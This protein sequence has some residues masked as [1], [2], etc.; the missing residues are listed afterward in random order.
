MCG[1]PKQLAH[2]GDAEVNK[3]NE[4]ARAHFPFPN[5]LRL[6]GIIHVI[7]YYHPLSQLVETIRSKAT[8][9]R[10][11]VQDTGAVWY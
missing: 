11:N 3:A 10:R 6:A 1:D 8:R 2:R 9:R 4:T 5:Q 7:V